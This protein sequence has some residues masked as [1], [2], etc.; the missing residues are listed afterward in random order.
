MAP[1]YQKADIL[2]LTSQTEAWS[3][4][5]TEAQAN[6]VIPIAFACSEGVKEVLSPDGINGFLVPPGDEE[7]FARTLVKVARM[8]EAE[9]QALRENLLRKAATYDVASAGRKWVELFRQLSPESEATPSEA[10]AESL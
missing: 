5:L 9:K 1:W 4:S 8:D 3:L 7:A 2:C 6:G 10:A